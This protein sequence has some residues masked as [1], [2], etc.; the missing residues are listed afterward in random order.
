MNKIKLGNFLADLR[1]EKG[2]T[3]E[4]LAE[5]INVNYKTISKWEC[6]N[7]TPS[8]ET[9]TELSKIFEVSLYE[10]SNCER[11]NNPFI[12]KENIKKVINKDNI[13]H[14]FIIK[15]I[16][17]IISLIL[18]VFI[19]YSCIYTINN[20]NQFQVYELMSD[21]LTI[22]IKGFLIKSNNKYYLSINHIN[23]L[24]DILS[25]EN[26]SYLEYYVTINNIKEETTIKNFDKPTNIKTAFSIIKIHI[27][28]NELNRKPNQLH[29]NIKYKNT[30]NEIIDTVFKL[31]VL[32]KRS[33]NKL[34]Y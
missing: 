34:F 19:T 26:I 18:L 6:G 28:D 14:F 16:A 21:N 23:Y 20:Y 2:L 30:E 1:N 31:I 5:M 11:I 25:H 10:L 3:Q 24:D 29:L 33:N 32:N 15:L 8:L 12:S 7:S 17:L 13:K 9:L 22:D 27:S 4:Q